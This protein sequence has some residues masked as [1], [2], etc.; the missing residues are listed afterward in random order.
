MKSKFL[1]KVFLTKSIKKKEP[2]DNLKSEEYQKYL[3]LLII[4]H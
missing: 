1:K 3:I 2:L 4:S